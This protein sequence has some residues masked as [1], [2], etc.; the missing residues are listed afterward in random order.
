MG[1]RRSCASLRPRRTVHPVHKKGL[2]IIVTPF[3]SIGRSAEI[4]T[5]DPHNP[6]VV[7]YQAALRS[8]GA[9]ILGVAARCVNVDAYSA[10]KNL[11]DL[12]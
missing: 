9:R 6:I 10:S 2:R 11:Q 12:F 8:A 3:D 7:R 5:P 4:R 1:M